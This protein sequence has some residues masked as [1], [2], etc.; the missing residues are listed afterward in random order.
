M[1]LYIASKIR[2]YENQRGR[3]TCDDTPRYKVVKTSLARASFSRA[4]IVIPESEMVIEYIA[5]TKDA[6]YA[7]VLDGGFNRIVRVEHGSA[8]QAETLD[9]PDDAAR[10]TGRLPGLHPAGALPAGPWGMVAR[11]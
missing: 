11:G 6:L 9:L 10:G 8:G 3:H 1:M 4:G 5:A 7:G 2:I